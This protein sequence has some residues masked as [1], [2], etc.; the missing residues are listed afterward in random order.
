MESK[1]S[2]LINIIGKFLA[3]RDLEDLNKDEL[4][5]K[6]SLERVDVLVLLGSSI[7][8]NIKIV[9]EAYEKGLCKKIL[10]CGGIGH[11]TALLRNSV[12]NNKDYN[13]IEVHGKSEANI[14][15]DIIK[16]YF[17]IS[18]ND[19]IIENKSTNCGDN[20]K[21]AIEILDN[22]KVNYNSLMLIQDPTMQLRS[23]LSFLKYVNNNVKVI[24]YSPFIPVVNEDMTFK[25]FNIDGI[26]D[27]ARFKELLIGE[28]PRLRD[29]K[30]GYGPK[31]AGYI[32]HIDIPAEVEN[33]YKELS[34]TL[35][36]KTREVI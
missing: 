9:Q 3:R 2:N 11:S 7:T 8:Y 19:I 32:E 23:H 17:K 28:I 27:I 22:M 26:W 35:G 6:F 12:R 20:A 5:K 13:D 34:N 25:N 29:D 10:I 24:S 21:K 36:L 16:K 1:K 15:F 33:A 18:E 4:M 30:N 31:G 14:I